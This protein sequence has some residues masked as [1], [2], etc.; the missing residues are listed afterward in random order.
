MCLFAQISQEIRIA[1]KNPDVWASFPGDPI[2]GR[3]AV[4]GPDFGDVWA[5]PGEAPFWA[6]KAGRCQAIRAEN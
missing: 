4:T 1:K 6:R 3:I 2:S 5:E